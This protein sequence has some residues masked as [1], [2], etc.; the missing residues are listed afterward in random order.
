MIRPPSS[1]DSFPSVAQPQ[2]GAAAKAT[3]NSVS[4]QASRGDHETVVREAVAAI[5]QAAKSLNASV[6]LSVDSDS[7]RAIVRVVDTQT[8]QL[9]RQIPTEE[10]LELRRALDRIAGLLIH[11]TA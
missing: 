3:A 11:R 4:L 8:R 7:G 6:E 2:G 1:L 5:N 9:I 10:A